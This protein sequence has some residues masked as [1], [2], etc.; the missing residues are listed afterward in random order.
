MGTY[1]FVYTC[2]YTHADIRY[3]VDTAPHTSL[4][5]QVA[6]QEE[7]VGWWGLGLGLG[8]RGL[9][10]GYKVG[11]RKLGW[12]VIQKVVGAG[13]TKSYGRTRLGVIP[14]ANKYEFPPPKRKLDQ[15]RLLVYLLDCDPRTRK[16]GFP[17]G[18]APVEKSVPMSQNSIFLLIIW[19]GVLL[20]EL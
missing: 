16:S 5:G 11:R 6:N 3:Y 12:G 10:L 15:R 4:E 18:P 17:C 1:T 2:W 19:F 14:K 13:R 9:R 7:E 8:V 20:F